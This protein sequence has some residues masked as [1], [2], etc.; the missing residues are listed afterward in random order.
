LK[1]EDSVLYE[2]IIFSSSILAPEPAAAAGA[3]AADNSAKE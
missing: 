3:A 2:R 1:F